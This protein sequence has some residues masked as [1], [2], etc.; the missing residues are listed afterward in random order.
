MDYSI[1]MS[2]K[3]FYFR[4]R[5]KDLSKTFLSHSVEVTGS[6]YFENNFQ[7]MCSS[8][9]QRYVQNLE[10]NWNSSGCIK[11]DNFRKSVN[12]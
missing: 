2:E 5:E 3:Y 9:S 10:R 6:M 12:F 11:V 7:I 4:K 8:I 1:I